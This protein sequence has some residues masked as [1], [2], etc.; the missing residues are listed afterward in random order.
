[1]A[2]RLLKL[3]FPAFYDSISKMETTLQQLLFIERAPTISL[4]CNEKERHRAME[5]KL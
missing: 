2:L 4:K 5:K 3:F 1:M